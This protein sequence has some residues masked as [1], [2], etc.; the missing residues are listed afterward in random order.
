[1]M[2]ALYKLDTSGR[3]QY[4]YIHDYQ[5]N[6]FSPYSYTTVWGREATHGRDRQYAFKTRF[7]MDASLKALF[8]KKLTQGYKILYSYPAVN[9][10]RHMYAVLAREKAS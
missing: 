5:G 4:Y 10:Y 6:L 1:M 2:I 9:F 7:E 3:D 8:A